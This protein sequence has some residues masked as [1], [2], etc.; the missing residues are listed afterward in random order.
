MAV[1]YLNLTPD[2]V[3]KEFKPKVYR[4][5]NSPKQS[6]VL[7]SSVPAVKEEKVS[8]VVRESVSSYFSF[9]IKSLLLV[10]TVSLIIFLLNYFNLFDSIL[11][12]IKSITEIKSRLVINSEFGKSVVYMDDKEIGETPIDIKGIAPGKKILRIKAKENPNNFYIE[13]SIPIELT[14]GQTTL[15]NSQIGPSERTSSFFIVF[16]QQNNS[17]YNFYVDVDSIIAD[18][19]INGIKRGTT[20]FKIKLDAGEY[21]VIIHKDGYREIRTT[22]K[23]NPKYETHVYGKLYKFILKI[24]ELK[25]NEDK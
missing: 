2:D 8:Q 22:V 4:K 25:D 9:I 16:A 15:V 1:R 20:P 13:Q 24:D 23:I 7:K 21:D 14:P 6:K 12:P 5:A 17:E 18:V 11:S 19:S 3:K 10:F